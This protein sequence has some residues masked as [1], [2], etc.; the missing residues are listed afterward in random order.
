MLRFNFTYLFLLL[1]FICTSAKAAD[2]S[3]IQ[4]HSGTIKK[5]DTLTVIDDKFT[6]YTTEQW[7]K[8][9]NISVQN[10]VSFELRRDTNI[11]YN[12]RSFVCSLKLT[13]EYYRTKEQE[14]PDEFKD[15]LLVVNS[16]T[17]KGA[18]SKLIDRFKFSD[19]HKVKI[20]VN[21]IESPEWKDSIP[22]VFR[23]HNQ[24][25]VK[26]LYPFNQSAK[27]AVT[28]NLLFPKLDYIGS[29]VFSFYGFSVLG[30]NSQV[31]ISWQESDLVG[32]IPSGWD[33]DAEEY[34]LEWTYVDAYDESNT[35]FTQPNPPSSQ[36]LETLMQNNATR[37]TL[38]KVNSY[39]IPI[40]YPQ[41]YLV[42]RLRRAS[43]NEEGVRLVS[44]QWTYGVANDL[45]YLAITG[46]EKELTWQYTSNFAEGG[47]RKEVISYFDGALKNRQDVTIRRETDI[48]NNS[49]PLGIDNEY[50]IVGERAY[51]VY[52]RPVVNILPAPSLSPNLG[53]KGN[54]NRSGAT[55]AISHADINLSDNCVTSVPALTTGSGA[56]Q[57]YSSSNP[58][59]ALENGSSNYFAK[60]VPTANGYPYAVTEFSKDMTGRIRAQGGVGS[61]FQLTGDHSTKY[62][63]GRPLQSELNRIFGME[64]G[65]A[66]HYSKN[67]VVDAN[68]QVS[69]SYLNAKGQTIATALAGKPAANTTPLPSYGNGAAITHINQQLFSTA[70]FFRDP[71][72]LSLNAT[73]N[74]LNTSP[75]QEFT[76]HY[77]IDP[78]KIT[79]TPLL[80][81]EFCTNCFYEILVTVKDDCSNTIEQS[82]STP[83]PGN[84]IACTD[85]AQKI[86][87][88]LHFTAEKV[89]EYY[90]TY[91]IQLSDSKINE[92]VERYLTLNTD[93]HIIQSLFE[94]ELELV[95]FFGCYTECSDCVEK[96]GSEQDFINRVKSI[97]VALKNEKFPEYELNIDAS[98]ITDIISAKYTSLYS[99]CV[100]RQSSCSSSPCDEKL[101]MIKMDVRPGGQYAPVAYSESTETYSILEAGI[102]VLALYNNPNNPEIYSINYAGASGEV[103]YIRDLNFS[104]FVK[105]YL[106]HPEWADQF[107]KFHIEYC[108]YLWCKDVGYSNPS[109]NNEKSYQFDAKLRDII[110]SGAKAVSQGLYNRSNY[111]AIVALD[112]FFATGGRGNAYKSQIEA[113][114][115]NLSNVF[116]MTLKN[117]SGVNMNSKNI[118]QLIDW[119]LYCK[120]TSP[121]ATASD[122]TNSWTN[123]TPDNNCRSVSQEWEMFRNYYLRLKTKYFQI[124]KSAINPSCTNCYI[125]GDG[126]DGDC[127]EAPC[128]LHRLQIVRTDDINQETPLGGNTFRIEKQTTVS[129]NTFGGPL[130]RNV[131]VHYRVI[132]HGF[133]EPSNGAECGTLFSEDQ[134]DSY[135]TLNAG[136]TQAQIGTEYMNLVVDKDFPGTLGCITSFYARVSIEFLSY[137][138]LPELT[139]NNSS[140][141]TSHP[142]RLAYENK[143]RIFADYVNLDNYTDCS[144]EQNQTPP[145][146]TE[147][148][149][150]FASEATA[151]LA[152]MKKSWIS[153]LKEARAA[154]ASNVWEITDQQIENLVDDLERIAA[155][156]I[157]Y[158]SQAY[159]ANPTTVNPLVIRPASTLPSG[160]VSA[161]GYNT[162]MEA[163]I[164]QIN[165]SY[166]YGGFGPHLLATPYPYDKSPIASN[167]SGDRISSDLC[168]RLALINSQFLT[169]QPGGTNQQFHNW[170]MENVSDYY[171]TESQLNE[172]MTKCGG[173]CSYLTESVI[174]PAA[175]SVALPANSIAPFLSCSEFSSL[176]SSFELIYPYLYPET[177]TARILF[178]NFMNHALGYSL[179]YAD[180][181]EFEANC[182]GS[183]SIVL[184]NR[185]SNPLLQENPFLCETDVLTDLFN[186]VG[187]LYSDF[188]NKQRILFRNQLVATC[189]S[190][191]AGAKLEGDLTEYHYTLYY[192]DQSGLLVKTVPPEGVELLTTE[193]LQQIEELNNNPIEN[194]SGT[195]APSVSDPQIAF[196]EFS[197]YTTSGSLK[198]IELWFNSTDPQKTIRF[199]SPDKKYLF[200][201]AVANNKVWVEVFSMVSSG[202]DIELSLTN[203]ITALLP[204]SVGITEWSHVILQSVDG[205]ATGAL[206]VYY[207]GIKLEEDLAGNDIGYPFEYEFEAT[208]TVA[209]IPA[210]IIDGLK[211]LRYYNRLVDGQEAMQNFTNLCRSPIGSLA[212]YTVLNPANPATNPLLF[213]AGISAPY[214]G[215]AGPVSQVNNRGAIEITTIGSQPAIMEG[216]QSSFTVEFWAK[217]T[218]THEI[219][220]EATSGY[221]GVSG[222]RF[223]ISP[224]N[225]DHPLIAA[226]G[227]SVGINGVS[228]YEHAFGYIPAL[229][230]WQ[231]TITDWTHIS[232]VYSNNRPSLYINGVFVKQGLQ[233]VR[234]VVPSLPFLFGS[235]GHMDGAID[236]IRVWNYART[237]TQISANYNKSIAPASSGGLIG[238]WPV[239]VS[240]GNNI[241]DV[242][243]SQT[244]IP[245]SDEYLSWVNTS[246]PILSDYV[247][248]ELPKKP[249]IEPNHRLKTYYAYNSLNQVVQQSTPDAGVSKFWYDRLGRL[250]VSQN[251]KQK[252]VVNSFEKYS[253][254]KYDHLN[255]ILE[256]GEMNVGT[257]DLGA[258]EE[259]NIRTNISFP[260]W[261]EAREKTELTLTAYDQVP[262]WTPTPLLGA[263]LNLRKRV[264]ATAVLEGGNNPATNRIAGSYYSYDIG[265]NV[266]RLVQ[267]NLA[268]GAAENS[269]VSNGSGLKTIDYEFDLISGKVNKVLYQHGK[270]D[271]FYHW[272]KYDAENRLTDVLTS[273]D[274]INFTE[275]QWNKEA[276]Y[277]YY[278]HGPLARTILGQ[279]NVQGIDYA[280]TLQGWLKGV[281]SQ[282]LNP[283]RD[284]GNDGHTSGNNTSIMPDVFGYSLGYFG[285]DYEPIG[286]GVTAFGSSYSHPAASA[287][288]DITGKALYNGNISQATYAI[289]LL[290]N[291][292]TVG[293]SYQYD[294]LNR[295]LRVNRHT[296]ITAGSSWGNGSI[297]TPFGENFSYDANGNILA[298]SRN[299]N[300]GQ[301]LDQLSYSY[302]RNELGKLVNNKLRDV[303]D[304]SRPQ[305]PDNYTYDEIGNLTADEAEGLAS[306][307]WTV[308][309]KIRQITK[310][311]GSTIT[312]SYDPSG[313]RVRKVVTQAGGSPPLTT[314]Y[315]RDAQ[316]NT[317]AVYE[318][319]A[320]TYKWSEQHLYGSSRLGIFKPAFE[321]ALSQPLGSDAYSDVNDPAANGIFGKKFFELSNHLGNVMVSV[322]DRTGQQMV[323][324]NLVYRA[325]ELSAQD[326]YAFGGLMPARQVNVSDYRYG[327]NGK[328][329]DNEV[330]GT[331][332]QQDYGMRIY[333]TRIGKF[334]SADPLTKS[335]ADLTP[336]QFASN[337]P[338]QNIDLDGLEGISSTIPGVWSPVTGKYMVQGD[339]NGDMVVDASERESWSRAMSFWM[340]GGAATAATLYSGGRAAPLLQ[341]MYWWSIANPQISS[342][343]GFTLVAAI[344]GYEG[345]DLPGPADDAQRTLRQIVKS[346]WRNT[347]GTTR[348]KAFEALGALTKY[349]SW[350]WVGRLDKGFF[351]K[352]DFI[353]DFVGVQL[354][355]F[356]GKES[357][358]KVSEYKLFIDN[359]ADAVDEG[360]VE[361]KDMVW[362]IREARLDILVPEALI[363]NRNQKEYNK[364]WEKFKEV[365]DYGRS[366]GIRVDISDSMENE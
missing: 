128:D 226:M 334:L 11:Y 172:F 135:L 339:V 69:V 189:L 62:Y 347:Y 114:L 287:P 163:F 102:N 207:N 342:E 31:L 244:H 86:S 258:I 47:K 267:E 260:S 340:I 211:H 203:Q 263:Q 30:N 1:L 19:G 320:T 74:F 21:S 67:A 186:K 350:I 152:G 318:Q 142:N 28:M 192:Y 77:E 98:N 110:T 126:T 169:I 297:A 250:T 181:I 167:E 362:R 252:K 108:S 352:V 162:F 174:F 72:S 305:I 363:R 164:D 132:Q 78:A 214:C 166:L 68:K 231:G 345:P 155:K 205:I 325:E 170:L 63:Y 13:I 198:S 199:V 348:G 313:N 41:G 7:N 58:F 301:V 190:T 27:P 71:S 227:V 221:G 268:Q 209:T 197:N 160:I 124:V 331:G 326:Y 151:T 93:L 146:A 270:W 120:P 40:V 281:N 116:K 357:S 99:E 310:S 319:S 38:S 159:I 143:N 154:N 238:Y 265:G 5:G 26:R 183:S 130:Q 201:S 161:D 36:E 234:L 92:Q 229:L 179:T 286:T 283:G 81:E 328:E 269:Y 293:N 208:P 298:L 42:A 194:C 346:V 185:A 364:I 87:A 282:H 292:E 25:V 137:E 290:N 195:T 23:I 175:F 218:T 322:S 272:Y 344:S 111:K 294:Q 12:S 103:I 349:E 271:Q 266:Y 54:F 182:A 14:K 3:Y 307:S 277:Q 60:F 89:G 278:L 2:E 314:F 145:T 84:L 106:A 61:T 255:R 358:F 323:G 248:Q 127:S 247:Y 115:D 32:T 275:S 280:Y 361:G 171:L 196:T 360:M 165:P 22:P 288:G 121:T 343:V 279:Q 284:M 157:E 315:T 55:T 216:G 49:D 254:T 210:D 29:S 70:S 232:V 243:C 147:R 213:W 6:Y 184:F 107:A 353:K 245:F 139:N 223:A 8:L 73:T 153:I 39:R 321:V 187:Q 200:Q 257:D 274:N 285:A 136:Q 168:N 191:N 90:I 85:N 149:G 264:V 296:A 332:N 156:N 188:L 53:Y 122:L 230:V 228:V 129:V 91:K 133:N 256:A 18:I 308:Y 76:V 125:G 180:Y 303:Q 148:A 16:D 304:P 64:V 359:L 96:L 219:D 337:N 317:M 57:Y 235:Y 105:A 75:N 236:E 324:G 48:G 273:R 309:G 150:V 276:K 335:Y 173:S 365:E 300:T 336:F 289:G 131:R 291:G 82:A 79:T 176:K 262:S 311:N 83:F 241:I 329:M 306:I 80:S 88:D 9:R 204:S 140:L 37:V 35:L 100:S 104:D 333:D 101:E 50:A 354:K 240:D 113:D 138:C 177:K 330:K 341:K 20:I 112:P 178:T 239:S 193:Q 217:P 134:Y 118:V 222:Q 295:L 97:L 4:T 52:G 302:T 24:I 299:N 351:P 56:S 46:H 249:I 119:I 327:F 45:W 59:I 51:D 237:A 66:I 215:T 144:I 141:C 251:A 316:G 355:T 43:Y 33:D 17:A 117:S 261:L 95:D 312:Y 65:D 109:F 34:D 225:I 10:I 366:R 44:N 220:V 158:Q 202:G 212:N 338:I 224:S 15:V 206:E 123:C 94:S 259:S 242:S 233:S 246:I 253:Y 356:N